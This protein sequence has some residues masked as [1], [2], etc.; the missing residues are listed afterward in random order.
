LLRS[1][2]LPGMKVLQFAFGDG[3]ENLY[4][5][6]NHVANSVVYTGTHDNE[7]T[8]GWWEG[9]DEGTR[10]DVRAYIPN[11]ER[12]GAAWGLTR[13][14][15]AS[16]AELAIIPLQDLLNLDNRSRMNQPGS[17]EGNWSWRLTDEPLS[18]E[19]AQSLAQL[20][21]LYGRGSA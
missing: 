9:L 4:L 19:L 11:I 6:H 1:V 18:Q 21:R 14:A 12:E 17:T 8:R 2:E 20:N 13:T 16:V 15:L 7:T 3:P 10:E 5:P